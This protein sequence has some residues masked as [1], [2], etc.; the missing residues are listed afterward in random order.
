MKEVEGQVGAPARGAFLEIAFH[1]FGIDRWTIESSARGSAAP[2]TRRV[3]PVTARHTAR[4]QR[5][6]WISVISS[7]VRHHSHPPN[8]RGS[9][10]CPLATSQRVLLLY[11]FLAPILNIVESFPSKSPSVGTSSTP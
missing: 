1:L 6:H 5:H 7:E 2:S 10:R 11:I 9:A 4:C 8:G 3:T